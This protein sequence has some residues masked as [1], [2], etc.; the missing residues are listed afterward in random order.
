MTERRAKPRKDDLPGPGDDRPISLERWRRHREQLMEWEGRS[1][2]RPPEWWLYER[3]LQPPEAGKETELLLAMGEL[4]AAELIRLEP[5]WRV[6][7]D[8]AQA[9]GFAF[10]IGH[11]QPHETFATWLDGDEAKRAHYAWAGIPKLLLKTWNAER[12]RSKK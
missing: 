12:R 4:S 2:R 7:Y 5:D 9:P 3:K 10:C 11:A 8:R 1:G 6:E